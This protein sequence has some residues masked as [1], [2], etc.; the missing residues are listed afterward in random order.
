MKENLRVVKKDGEK[1]KDKGLQRPPSKEAH[2]Q[3]D[4]V[5]F[6]GAIVG[7]VLCFFFCISFSCMN[8]RRS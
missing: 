5:G 2:G 7:L 3:K 8:T 4:R 1:E 6:L